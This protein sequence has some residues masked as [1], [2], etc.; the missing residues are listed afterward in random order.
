[1]SMS[2]KIAGA[3]VLLAGI[4]VAAVFALW[5]DSRTDP[6]PEAVAEMG[7]IAESTPVPPSPLLDEL[8]V[9]DDLNG[10]LR[11][12]RPERPEEVFYGQGVREVGILGHV[13]DVTASLDEM[14]LKSAIVARVRLRLV[15]A[16]G[17]RLAYE[18]TWND[19]V[20]YNGA[21]KFTLDVLEYLKGSGGPR[22]TAYAYGRIHDTDD[23]T[24]PT[25][26]EAKQLGKRLLGLRDTR[27]DNRDAMVFL[28]YNEPGDHYYLGLVRAESDLLWDFTVSSYMWKAWLPDTAATATSTASRGP[29]ASSKP[30][31][32][33]ANDPA[34]PFGN[35]LGAAGDGN[36]VRTPANTLP[37]G[38]AAAQTPGEQ[39]AQELT[40]AYVR[41]RVAVAVRE[42]RGGDGSQ[43]YRDCVVFKYEWQSK[44]N[45][46]T[47][48]TGWQFIFPPAT[49]E[50][51]S[52]QPAGTWAFETPTVFYIQRDELTPVPG[53]RIWTEGPGSEVLL[54]AW[55]GVIKLARPLPAGHYLVWFNWLA[56]DHAVCDAI[57][58]AR[59]RRLGYQLNVVA[60][61]TTSHESFF[62]PYA[63]STAIVGTTTVGT[64][65]WEAPLAGSGQAGRV[66]A[67]L[68]IDVTGHALD[69]I[70]L[71]GTT[72]L[73]LIVADATSTAGTLTWTSP[74]Q[75]WSAGDKLMLRVRRYEA[76]TP[77]PTP[78]A[79]PT[80]TPTPT[81]APTPTPTPIP[82]DRPVV[83]FKD[84]D[85][86]V[87]L[88]SLS[89]S[90]GEVAWVHV[91]AL[92]LSRSSSYTIELTRVNE[93]PAGGVGIVFHYQAC[94]YTPQSISVSSGNTTYGRT[95][96]VKLC[97]GSGGTVTAVLKRGSAT[98]ATTELDVSTPP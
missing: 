7:Q 51:P 19:G 88:D 71:D 10:A 72:T 3:V 8:R 35:I 31:R 45:Q 22:L 80:P 58:E 9:L 65:S 78:T 62:D 92:N 44:V 84:L 29:R 5:R 96:P 61:P 21:L 83:L 6:A 20:G 24:A 75:P 60:S 41:S 64:I 87:V 1:M 69:F 85:T 40:A 74:T 53:D 16:A 28:R 54:G 42:L 82:T 57:P 91:K 11:G 90:V 23:Y 4:A 34:S 47:A 14:V 48:A 39:G 95:M 13:F 49:A 97:T 38:S 37:A 77:T 70:G 94:G 59:K 66:T 55:P 17:V 81:P 93:E 52:G 89:L 76:P 43:Q 33:L 67:D 26:E 2:V 63:S 36:A 32:F 18:Y 86:S 15:E 56:A 68:T 27:W 98:L 30:Q 79:T 46:E 25:V 12:V 50:M 73:S